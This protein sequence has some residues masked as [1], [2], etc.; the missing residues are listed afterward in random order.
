MAL[1][2]IALP[3]AANAGT[4]EPVGPAVSVLLGTPTSFPA[5]QPFHITHGWAVGATAPPQAVG[6]YAFRLEVDGVTRAPDFITRT[7]DSPQSTGYD[8]PV[9]NR[10]WT[11]NF[12]GGM[13]GT[14]TFTGH[15]IEPCQ[16]VRST[17]A[18]PNDPVDG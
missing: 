14:H 17:C 6:I 12:P 2:L 13:T 3:A 5:G 8:A 4:N 10:S 11:F 16:L 7:A 18:T 15:W 1:A 9:L